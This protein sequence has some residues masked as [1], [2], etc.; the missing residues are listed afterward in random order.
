MRLTRV[1]AVLSFFALAACAGTG[2]TG[3]RSG[4]YVEVDNPLYTQSPGAPATVWV[5]RSSV[6]EGPPRGG[7]IL[8]KGYEEM[9]QPAAPKESVPGQ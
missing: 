2:A 4:E 7:V 9:L 5:P 6:E 3:G 8:R 1:L